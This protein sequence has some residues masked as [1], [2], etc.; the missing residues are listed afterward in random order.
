MS[1]FST[2]KPEK[3][4]KYYLNIYFSE[5]APDDDT[6]GDD[7]KYFN[8]RYVNPYDGEIMRYKHSDII[9]AEDEEA[10]K[11]DKSFK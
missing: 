10:T 1:D 2:R 11:Y 8:C 6:A 9:E 3:Y 7:F 5:G 4:G